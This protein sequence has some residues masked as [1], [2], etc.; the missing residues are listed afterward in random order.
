MTNDLIERLVGD[1]QPVP[2]TAMLRLLAGR[3]AAGLFLSALFMLLVLGLRPDLGSAATGAVFWIKFGYTAGIAA[4]GVPA[5][6]ALARPGG[7]TAWPWVTM[8]ALVAGLAATAWAQLSAAPEEMREELVVGATA[9]RCPFYI[10]AVAAPV[11]AATLAFMRRMAPTR[12]ALAG[13]AAGLL[14]GGAGACIYSLHCTE[15]GLPFLLT[16]Y[17]SGIIFVSVLGMGLGKLVLRW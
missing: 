12:P 7:R 10:V 6:L 17:T 9:L 8:V 11:L 13:L 14:S 5:V 1:L 2:R 15:I 3:V 16:W 4:L